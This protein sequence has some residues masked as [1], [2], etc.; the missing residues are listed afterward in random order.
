M[1]RAKRPWAPAL[2]LLPRWEQPFSTMAARV[3]Y[4]GRCRQRSFCGWSDWSFGRALDGG[5]SGDR[6]D[7]RLGAGSGRYGCLGGCSLDG[8]FGGSWYGSFG[9]R[10]C[11]RRALSLVTQW[12]GASGLDVGGTIGARVGE[13]AGT[14]VLLGASV[15]RTRGAAVLGAVT[16]ARV[17]I[18]G[19]KGA[20]VGRTIGITIGCHVVGIDGTGACGR[21]VDFVGA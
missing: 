14:G 3:K 19:D 13:T 17:G 15:G 21:M 1:S 18:G 20:L 5:Q 12:G 4:Q 11:D 6:C 9:G 7:R 10:W 2:L 16:G 8:S